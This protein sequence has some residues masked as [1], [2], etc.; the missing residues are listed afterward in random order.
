VNVR[1]HVVGVTVSLLA[2]SSLVLND[3]ASAAPRRSVASTE[4]AAQSTAGTPT[5]TT[6]AA[7]ATT[8]PPATR[9]TLPSAPVPVLDPATVSPSAP[10]TTVGASQVPA[11]EAVDSA[12]VARGP[13]GDLEPSSIGDPPICPGSDPTS[14]SYAAA[15]K[16]DCPVGYWPLD[17]TTGTGTANDVRNEV[18]G[19]Y[20]NTPTN[21][22]GGAVGGAKRFDGVDDH[23]E[24]AFSSVTYNPNH[25]KLTPKP[26]DP[27]GA[28]EFTV[29]MWVK[30]VRVKDFGTIGLVGPFGGGFDFGG[31]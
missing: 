24:L 23:V 31:S 6:M 12:P 26:S 21:V 22:T 5:P 11:S 14:S 18:E 25:L 17:E 20:R 8:L 28:D 29:E 15:V 2:T 27:N 10:P 13:V 3:L 16:F 4:I 30:A 19:T 1:R 9:P 7:P